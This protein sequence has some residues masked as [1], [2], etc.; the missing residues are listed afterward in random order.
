MENEERQK[1]NIYKPK[2]MKTRKC[3]K[4]QLADEVGDS[5]K[6]YIVW[7]TIT[8]LPHSLSLSLVQE[9]FKSL[10][11]SRTQKSVDATESDTIKCILTESFQSNKEDDEEI[12]RTREKVK[13]ESR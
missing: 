6:T 9:L 5:G 13:T 1:T 12:Q 2:R 4:C 3:Q 11:S 10:T 8:T 7:N